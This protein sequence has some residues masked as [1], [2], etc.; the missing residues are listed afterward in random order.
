MPEVGLSVLVA[1]PV[2]YTAAAIIS[3]S[4]ANRLGVWLGA[5]KKYGDEPL[6][7]AELASLNKPLLRVWTKRDLVYEGRIRSLSK[8]A[9]FNE[10]AIED[11]VAYRRN[12]T[13]LYRLPMVFFSLDEADITIEVI[14][15]AG[16]KTIGSK[17]ENQ[18]DSGHHESHQSG[19][20]QGM[21]ST[22]YSAKSGG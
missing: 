10:L 2:A 3:H 16:T 8:E 11:V 19:G 20:N 17:H 6:F 21:G 4:F 13:P 14:P 15:P 18:R 1:I 22:E 9:G 5:T 12:L 7:Y